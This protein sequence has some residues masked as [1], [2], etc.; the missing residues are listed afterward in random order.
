LELW[1]K[2]KRKIFLL[3]KDRGASEEKGIGEW[4][5]WNI[6]GIMLFLIKK[7]DQQ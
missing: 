4:L 2:L 7:H 3:G 5:L 1:K 6:A